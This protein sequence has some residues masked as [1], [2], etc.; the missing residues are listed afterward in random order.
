MGPT[1]DQAFLSF[2]PG[3]L[4]DSPLRINILK[5]TDTWLA[6]D[7]PA[8]IATRQYPWNPTTANLDTALNKQLLNQKP[9]LLKL[10]ATLFGSAYIMDTEISGVA[11]FAKNRSSTEKLRNLVGSEK[12]GFKFIFIAKTIDESEF[13][14]DAPLL[15]HNTKP[16][17]IP[18]TAKGKKALTHFRAIQK[19]PLGWSLWE[20]TTAFPRLHQVRAHAAV[21]GISIFGDL[22]YSGVEASP[23]SEL[24][25]KTPKFKIQYPIFRGIALHLSEVDLP[26]NSGENETT[27]LVA[28]LPKHFRFLLKRLQLDY[29]QSDD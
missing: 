24:K 23:L 8:G 13:T 18:S 25:Q 2:P 9:E 4:N 16:K 19:S 6:I 26:V 7:K 5:N 11:L 28:N 17:M 10:G 27:Q 20:A 1:N 22:L 29:T 14:E 15:P 3:L 21:Q 12:V